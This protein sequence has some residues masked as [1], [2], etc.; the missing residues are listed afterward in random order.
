MVGNNSPNFGLATTI[1]WAGKLVTVSIILM[2]SCQG[3]FWTFTLNNWTQP[4]VTH[5]EEGYERGDFTYVGFA[6]EI[7]ANGTPH[8]QGYVELPLK[9]HSSVVQQLI[10]ARCSKERRKGTSSEARD[11]F[12]LEYN[13]NGK[14]KEAP[15]PEDLFE[16]GTLSRS[17]Q[18]RR[19][20]IEDLH[21]ALQ[22]K[23]SMQEI[24]NNH[25][26]CFLQYGR[27]IEKYIFVNS[28]SRC[29][30]TCVHVFHGVTKTGKSRIVHE[31]Y[32]DCY[33]VDTDPV[34]WF[35]GYS[36][37]DVALFEEFTG[38]SASIKRMLRLLDRYKCKVPIKGGYVQWAPRVVFITSNIPPDAW[39]GNAHPRHVDALKRRFNSVTEFDDKTYEKLKYSIF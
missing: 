17:K 20:D 3:K 35:D 24:S 8:L 38:S 22:S 5:L 2:S 15:A 39:Y 14:T 25:F 32:P 37:Q 10:G 16:W 27:G 29:W 31:R 21:L 13:K 36:G 18:G 34:Q 9:K 11:Y 1:F 19:S 23:K 6:K 30:E 12:A 28:A 7:G 33:E 26:R 4:E